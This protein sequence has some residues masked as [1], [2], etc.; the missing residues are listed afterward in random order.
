MYVI[1]TDECFYCRETRQRWFYINMYL[2]ASRIS[3]SRV[4]QLWLVYTCILYVQTYTLYYACT[5][6]TINVFSASFVEPG[7]WNFQKSKKYIFS[8]FSLFDSA[9]SVALIRPRH[10]RRHDREYDEYVRINKH[11]LLLY[12][13]IIIWLL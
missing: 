7:K 3:T 6:P 10:R 11:K 1:R 12:N 9:T 4:I 5:M 2:H 13:I 8:V